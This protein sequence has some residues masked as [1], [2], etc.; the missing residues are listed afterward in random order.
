[1]NQGKMAI[2]MVKCRYCKKEINK[3]TAYSPRS[4][5]YYCNENHYLSA[6]EKKKNTTKHSYKSAEGTD[7][8]AYTD[9]IQ[10]LYVNMYGWN[11]K[12]IKWQILMSQTSNL[13]KA[14]PTWTYDTILYIIW[15]MQEIL[16]LTLIS[17][18]SNWSP[19]SLVDYYALEAEQFYNECCEIQKSVENY[20]IEEKNIIIKSKGNKKVK[21]KPINMEDL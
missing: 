3:N 2:G 7:R 21:Y 17:K 9:A 18:E 6:I 16:E 10:D 1:M 19:L 4:G 5:M 14:N 12:A 20:A 8:R 15:Y 11:K 13:L